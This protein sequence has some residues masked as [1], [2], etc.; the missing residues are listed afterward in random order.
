YEDE[1]LTFEEH[2]RA[3][4]HLAHVL[5]DDWGLE[6]G[7]RVALAM[8]NF[9]E[10]SIAFWAA[11]VAGAIVVPLNAW[12]TGEELEYG[13]ADSGTRVLL[14]DGDR[15]QRIAPRLSALKSLERVV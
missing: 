10:W 1:R 6:K 11:A 9:P 2:Y 3:V 14:C 15:A 12:W 8:R 4:A 7:D 13:L 5:H